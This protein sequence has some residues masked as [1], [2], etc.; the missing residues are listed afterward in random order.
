MIKEV[1]LK[2]FDTNDPPKH[3]STPY[4][5]VND[6]LPKLFP[7]SAYCGAVGSGKT[8][9][10]CRLVSKYIELGAKDPVTFK[11]LMIMQRCILF[12][13]SIDSNP[14]W[15]AIPEENL[16]KADRISGYSDDKLKD[17]WDGIKQEK[18]LHDKY[19]LEMDLYNQMK[20][21][22]QRGDDFDTLP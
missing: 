13:P 15:N 18:R 1:Q 8:S 9:Q 5:I 17:I 10:A 21:S 4:P 6:E 7:C 14:V 19:K 22:L 3:E 16:T 20:T 2:H 11:P 12:S